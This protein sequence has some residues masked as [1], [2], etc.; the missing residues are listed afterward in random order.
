MSYILKYVDMNALYY[1]ITK[2]SKDISYRE[3]DYDC[4]VYNYNLHFD[5][6][7]YITIIYIGLDVCVLGD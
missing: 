3:Y 4:D 1:L 6:I 7:I 2:Y 5:H